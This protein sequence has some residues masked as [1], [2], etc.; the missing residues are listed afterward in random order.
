MNMADNS[1]TFF[2]SLQISTIVFG[3][4]SCCNKGSLPGVAWLCHFMAL[5]R[6]LEMSL[7]SCFQMKLRHLLD[8]TRLERSLKRA[9]A[10]EDRFT[11]GD[12]QNTFSR[13]VVR[14]C[15]FSVFP[16]FS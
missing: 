11:P 1:R 6:S 3:E 2:P 8:S 4:A 15:S 13:D 14:I 10:R 7:L 9:V 16:L 5:E 12:W